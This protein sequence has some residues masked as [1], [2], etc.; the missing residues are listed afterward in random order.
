MTVTLPSTRLRDANLEKT[1]QALRSQLRELSPQ[2]FK[3]AALGGSQETQFETAFASLG[4]TFLKDKAPKLLDYLV[5][6]QLVDRTEE[7]TKAVGVFG[8]QVGRDWVYAPLF[9][10]NGDVKGHEMLYLKRQDMFVPLKES[11]INYILSKQQHDLGQSVSRNPRQIGVGQP[12]LQSLSQPQVKMGEA[13]LPNVSQ[14]GWTDQLAGF[15]GPYSALTYGTLADSFKNGLSKSA[16]F[17]SGKLLEEVLAGDFRLCKL[18][19]ELCQSFPLI[20]QGFDRWHGADFFT[21]T[22][23]AMRE[24][25]S[26]ASPLDDSLNDVIIKHHFGGGDRPRRKK[27]M[28]TSAIDKVAVYNRDFADLSALSD[29]EAVEIF[30]TGYLVR[31]KRAEDE[32]SSAFDTVDSLTL[33]SPEQTGVYSLLQKPGKFTD[34]LIITQPY[35]CRRRANL[36]VIVDLD[37]KV[38]TVVE[39]S[40]AFV[41]PSEKTPAD[42]QKWFEGLSDSSPSVGGMYVAI[43]SSGS[44]SVPFRINAKLS[45]GKFRV[46]ATDHARVRRATDDG[47]SSEGPSYCSPTTGGPEMVWMDVREGDTLRLSDGT[48]YIPTNAKLIELEAPAKGFEDGYHSCCPG[49]D[50]DRTKRE[51]AQD[52]FDRAL[53]PGN[54]LDVE[55]EIAQ[56]TAGL[57][58]YVTPAEASINDG[59][60]Q[61]KTACLLSLVCEH[62]L[63]EQTAKEMLKAAEGR[64]RQGKPTRYRLRYA[65]DYPQKAAYSLQDG[66]MSG[67]AIPDEQVP[68]SFFGANTPANAPSQQMLPTD[69]APT[70][71][72][73]YDVSQDPQQSVQTAQQASQ[74]G[75]KEIFDTAMLSSMLKSVRQD[76]AIAKYSGDLMKAL[77][78]LGRILF[79]FYW[80]N[81]YFADRYGKGDLPELED[82]IRNSFDALGDLTLFLLE[83][84][85]EPLFG[86]ARQ[87]IGVDDAAEL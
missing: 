41:K 25:I 87:D 70:D 71:P 2:V 29:D 61:S 8:F 14:I 64:G 54:L 48:L 59:P 75:Q 74:L 85:A 65:P 10:L 16:G 63:R 53:Q 33:Q 38:W 26:Q 43:T 58:L 34:C 50:E 1:S 3:Q 7:E 39:P 36:Q 83:K 21:K 40:V 62:G 17:S 11:W 24:K 80:R 51:N 32:A 22:L 31:D 18:A 35:A 20:K 67:P 52:I 76:S 6:F 42:F 4:Y 77:D 47:R 12:D 66:G 72:S 78:R 37:S 5:G 45:E 60:L 27:K 46:Y 56:K 86:D 23:L 55:L 9:F 49:S 15:R 30:R 68:S 13:F 82:S 44:G 79:I 57:K 19:A 28:I 84:D 69:R 81:E 73:V